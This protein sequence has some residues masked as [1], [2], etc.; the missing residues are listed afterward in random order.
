[1]LSCWQFC[2]NEA[3]SAPDAA[4]GRSSTL[5]Q[6]QSDFAKA[7]W[8][9]AILLY[10]RYLRAVPNDYQAWNQ[11]AA[12]YYHSGQVKTALSTLQRIQKN[13]PSRSFNFFYQGM[14]IAVLYGDNGAVKYWE[15][16]THWADEFGARA[17]YELAIHHYRSR[18]EGKA[19]QLLTTYLQKFPRGPDAAAV[20]DLLKAVGSEKKIGDLKGF[21]RPDPELTI[22]K[23]HPFSL[24]KTPHFWQ[25]QIDSLGQESQGYQPAKEIGNLEEKNSSAYSLRTKSSIGV[26]PIRQQGA[27]SFAGYTYKQDWLIQPETLQ[28]FFGESFSLEAFPIR[29]DLMERSHQFFGDVR[30]QFSPSLFAGAYARIEF[31]RVGSSFF[32]SPDESSLKVVTPNRD[33]QLFIPWVGWTWNESSRSMLS[34]YLKKEIHRQSSEHS[35][36]TYDLNI[37]AGDPAISF[38]ISHA[39]DLTNKNLNLN[40]D[41]FQYE[42]IFNDY[43]L[44]NSRT[45]GLLGVNYAMF[46]GF[47]AGLVL[48]LYQD[49]Y[50]LPHVRTE[51]CSNAPPTQATSDENIRVY[52]ARKDAGQMAQVT[53]Y[54]DKS[55]NLRF[56]FRAL[57]VENKSNQKV[58]SNSE[59]AYSGGVSWSFP[60]TVRVTR[61]TER[62]AD[63][64]FTKDTDE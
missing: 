1:M 8:D 42:F 29:G 53:V 46:K 37:A 32:P 14:C 58:F 12:A 59:T 16:A 22:F 9:K 6:A 21:E 17:T 7:S 50:K 56:Q 11:L 61:M 24:F 31:S 10:R 44:D 25:L 63:A 41:L 30:K 20:K 33:V 19:K 35:N 60:G 5:S 64:A 57:M 36:K 54:Y 28:A 23:Y 40:V 3:K 39:I 26:G 15:Y 2:D 51:N 62:F 18:D 49:K 47:G 13:S 55:T 48:G 45:G 52:C 38:T 34:L 4:G 27:V 43:W